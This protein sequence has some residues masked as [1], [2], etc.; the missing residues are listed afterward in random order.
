MINVSSIG[1]LLNLN[2][3]N[4]K[5]LGERLG[6]DVVDAMIMHQCV[7]DKEYVERPLE[8]HHMMMEENHKN[9]FL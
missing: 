1:L 3:M 5:L 2:E 9:V 7:V 8:S 6:K 4:E